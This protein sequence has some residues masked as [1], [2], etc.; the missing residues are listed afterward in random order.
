M[1]TFGTFAEKYFLAKFR[2]FAIINVQD[3]SVYNFCWSS[4]S[5]KFIRTFIIQF[6][7]GNNMGLSK[8]HNGRNYAHAQ[9]SSVYNFCYGSNST[10]FIRMFNRQFSKGNKMGLLK[11][12]NGGNNVDAQDSSAYNFCSSSNST[13]FI[14]TF[15]RTSIALSNLW[16]YVSIIVVCLYRH[17]WRK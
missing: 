11:I 6:F 1:S 3:C 12:R 4:N 5:T 14:R 2:I 13:K 8:I 15:I 9:V 10:K 17:F 16:W 7:E